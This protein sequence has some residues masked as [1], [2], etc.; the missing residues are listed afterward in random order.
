MKSAD[1]KNFMIVINGLEEMFL[2]I[3]GGEWHSDEWIIIRDLDEEEL[4]L[5]NVVEDGM[6]MFESEDFDDDLICTYNKPISITEVYESLPIEVPFD[7]DIKGLF[8]KHKPKL[9]W[10]RKPS[11]LSVSK[12]YSFETDE[13]R[14]EYVNSLVPPYYTVE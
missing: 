3:K 13:E 6:R 2:V 5:C 14:W 11:N 8:N 12:L 4:E 7:V 9:L 1:L 10:K